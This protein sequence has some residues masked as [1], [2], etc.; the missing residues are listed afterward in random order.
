M[1]QFQRY[2]PIFR[3]PVQAAR[4]E[5][6]VPCSANIGFRVVQ[7]LARIGVRFIMHI[8]MEYCILGEVVSSRIIACGQ[9]GFNLVLDCLD[10]SQGLLQPGQRQFPTVIMRDADRVIQ[11][12]S[13]FTNGRLMHMMAQHPVLVKVSRMTDF[14]E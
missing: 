8:V 3:I 10:I 6:A 4:I 14:P 12:V 11:A 2:A 1:A 7:C 5:N 13:I 9:A